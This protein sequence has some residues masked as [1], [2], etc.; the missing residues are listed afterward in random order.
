VSIYLE[1]FA[2]RDAKAGEALVFC[3][4]Q[5][6]AGLLNVRAA[7]AMKRGDLIV[8]KDGRAWLDRE[9]EAEKA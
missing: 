7:E 1:G 3:N 2:D 4:R 6:G 8:M 5:T 9:E